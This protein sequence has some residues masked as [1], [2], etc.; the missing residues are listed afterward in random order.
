MNYFSN[1]YQQARKKFLRAAQARSAKQESYESPFLGPGEEKL[2]TDTALLA[3]G[4]EKVLLVI[5]SGTH[6]VEGF[7]GSSVQTGLLSEGLPEHLIEGIAVL[8]IHGINPYGFSH[9]RRFN[10]DNIDINRNFVKHPQPYPENCNHA[11]LAPALTPKSLG[12]FSTMQLF[13]TLIRFFLANG[14]KSLIQALAGGQNI[15]PQGLY[16]G[17]STETWSNTTVRSILKPWKNSVE[18][19]IVLD[20]HTGLGK[21]GNTVLLVDSASPTAWCRAKQWWPDLNVPDTTTGPYSA[22]LTGTLSREI[23]T[24]FP[25]ADEVTTATVEF[26]TEKWWQKLTLNALRS[27]RA[28]TW[29]THYGKHESRDLIQ[30]R[31]R[32]RK[33]FCPDSKEWQSQ[34][35][36]N[37]QKIIV[38]VL[39]NQ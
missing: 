29:L 33:T 28:E 14:T 15:Q 18:K 19:V 4:N 3:Q 26:G 9:L 22:R 6:G 8:M 23:H 1:T 11:E 5:T 37:A 17:G 31:Q 20:L 32:L 36:C 7:A 27:V 2:F 16:Y 21:F 25:A 35:W 34:V 38:N 30:A 13:F 39:K 10:E 12:F 24:M